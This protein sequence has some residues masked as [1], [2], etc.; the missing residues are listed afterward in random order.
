[1]KIG[2]VG[3]GAMGSVYG[4]LFAAAGHDVWLDAIWREHVDAI[5]KNGLHVTGASGERTVRP[6][7]TTKPSETGPCELL[8]LATKM[9]DV[10]AAAG[11]VKLLRGDDTVVR[12][13]ENG[14]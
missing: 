11:S 2:I 10:D 7:A 14:F 3:A 6:A 8:V 4:G 5:R 12:R 9:R 13:I 1:M